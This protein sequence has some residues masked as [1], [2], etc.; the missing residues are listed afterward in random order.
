MNL[1]VEELREHKG[2][3]KTVA[4]IRFFTPLLPS[5]MFF[6]HNLGYEPVWHAQSKSKEIKTVVTVN[7]ALSAVKTIFA[8]SNYYYS[9]A[10]FAIFMALGIAL[11]NMKPFLEIKSLIRND[12]R[13]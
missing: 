1:S 3:S 2:N 13:K 7:R 9:I 8:I 11:L 6:I 4:L 10:D 12:G 5:S